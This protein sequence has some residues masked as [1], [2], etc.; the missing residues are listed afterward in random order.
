MIQ[1]FINNNSNCPLPRHQS[2]VARPYVRGISGTVN[3][4]YDLLLLLSND[5]HR[6]AWIMHL[7]CLNVIVQNVR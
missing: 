7:M 4:D 3:K 2:F 5:K 1:S 6:E